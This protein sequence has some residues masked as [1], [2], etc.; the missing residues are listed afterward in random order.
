MAFNTAAIMGAGVMGEAMIVSLL[1]S[2]L[3]ADAILIRE[4]RAERLAEL[5]DRYGVSTGSLADCDLV[6]VAV[7]PQDVDATLTELAK[8]I[9]EKTLVISLLAGIKSAKFEEGLKPDTRVVRVMP[10]TPL[11]LGQGASG[12]ARGKHAID[13]DIEWV[14]SL[15]NNSGVAIE[16]S[17]D[18]MDAVTATSGSGPAY[19][20]RFV[21]AMLAAAIELGL[22][23]VEAALLVKETLIGAAKMI[24]D[25]GKDVATLRQNVTSPNGTTAAALASF[26]DSDIDGI[27]LRAMRAARD[28]SIELSN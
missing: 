22:G 12:V 3:K 15:L 20:F 5:I 6:I 26:N 16:V 4:K 9:S 11:L 2:G 10:N 25:S 24:A 18:L 28:R 27:V 13:S 21:E 7:K 17:E 14:I 8:E 23:E 19:V 1:R